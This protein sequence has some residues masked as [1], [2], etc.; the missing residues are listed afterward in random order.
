MLFFRISY[1]KCIYEYEYS[2]EVPLSEKSMV[3]CRREEERSF[4]GSHYDQHRV[5]WY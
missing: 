4:Y 3:L 1:D 2:L 5:Y